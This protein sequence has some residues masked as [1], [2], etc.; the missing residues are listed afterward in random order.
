MGAIEYS[1]EASTAFVTLRRPEKQ[2]ALTGA[3]VREILAAVA[4]A[5][6]D[7][8]VK[9]VVLRGEGK[10]FCAGFD[11]SDPDDFEGAPGEPRR[12]RIASVREKSEWM[13]ELF[14]AS[15]PLIAAVH[16][17]CIGIGMYLLLVADFAVASD[18]AGIG[19]PEERFGSA[20]ATW[21]YPFL[22][23]SVGLKR[24]NE[25]VMTGRRLSAA[26]AEHMGLVNRVV[27]RAELDA[28][29]ADLARALGSLPR[30]GIA[31]NRAARQLALSFT[32]H[33]GVFGF[34]AALHPLAEH[35]QREADE[36]DFM[37][38]IEKDG[39][40]AALEERNRRFGGR[41]WGW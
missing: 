26:E 34:H 23:L 39:M 3:M 6:A 22:I 5:G 14:G 36:F 11:V 12:A 30:D 27:P 4:R 8:D 32:G 35:L 38:A 15:K 41:W 17:S 24:A 33:Q 31:V 10:S 7:D 16:G 37:R 29:V 1:R 9:A 18:D 21:T 25:I 40:R 28:T 13:R 19:M 2:N 20:G